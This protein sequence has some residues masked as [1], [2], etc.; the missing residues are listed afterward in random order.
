MCEG[1]VLVKDWSKHTSQS[2]DDFKSEYILSRVLCLP[3]KEGEG[4]VLRFSW[5]L[6]IYMAKA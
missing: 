2:K 6:L 1:L 5:L 4:S 3:F